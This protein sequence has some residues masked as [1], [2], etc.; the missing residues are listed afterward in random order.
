MVLTI[1][2]TIGSIAAT[3]TKA[4]AL[5]GLAVQGLKIIGSAVM[6]IAKALFPNAFKPETTVEDLGDKAIQSGFKPEDFKSYEEYVKAA[7]EAGID[8]I[9]SGAG[10]PLNLPELVKG[11]LTKIAPIV[12]SRKA[13]DVIVRFW[14]KKYQKD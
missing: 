13:L 1:L 8:L 14:K 5:V 4:V 3:L 10:L 6:G 7:V 11:S 2:T 9:I 12:S